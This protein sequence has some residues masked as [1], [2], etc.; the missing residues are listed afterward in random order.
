MWAC[1]DVKR[2]CLQGTPSKLPFLVHLFFELPL[3]NTAKY[4]WKVWNTANC[5]KRPKVPKRT[6]RESYC[7]AKR[8]HWHVKVLG[9][10]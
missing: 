7:R 4:S 8:A 2:Y 9:T 5:S 10:S 3:E 1:F 6:C